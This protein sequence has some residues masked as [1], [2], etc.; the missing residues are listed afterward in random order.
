[1]LSGISEKLRTLIQESGLPLKEIEGHTGVS[2]DS[3]ARFL[4][5]TQSLRLTSAEDLLR[6]F[7]VTVSIDAPRSQMTGR[8]SPAGKSPAMSRLINLIAEAAGIQR[9]TS[10][11]FLTV[12]EIK[13]GAV[14]IQLLRR[15][16]GRETVIAAGI[17]CDSNDPGRNRANGLRYERTLLAHAPPGTI[18]RF[19]TAKSNWYLTIV[20][21]IPSDPNQLATYIE[22]MASVVRWLMS[23]PYGKE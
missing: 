19:P 4:N 16:R 14:K 3:I 22:G 23:L 18:E 11:H 7:R 17:A 10:G 1:M 5:G 12:E 9:Q 6:F 13:E 2:A 21:P 20:R 15:S 8:M